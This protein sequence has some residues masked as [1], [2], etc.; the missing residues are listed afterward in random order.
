MTSGSPADDVVPADA[1][2]DYAG[3]DQTARDLGKAEVDDL[4][5]AE[6]ARE[7]G[8]RLDIDCVRET[9][10]RAGR[11]RTTLRDFQTDQFRSQLRQAADVP[12][13][14][15]LG[16][17]DLASE[18][19][20]FDVVGQ[21]PMLDKAT[22]R[23]RLVDYCSDDIDPDACTAAVT[24]GTT[25]V[26]V[27]LVH[28]RA[29]HVQSAAAALNHVASWGL[30]ARRRIL[31]PCQARYVGWFAYSS[32]AR[33][34]SLVA[35]FGV[36]RRDQAQER[37][38]VRLSRNFR[39]DVL[40]AHPTHVL[41]YMTLLER[42]PGRGPRL[43]AVICFGETLTSALASRIVDFFGCPVRDMIGLREFSTIAAQCWAGSY[44]V[45]SER[46]WIEVVDPVTGAPLPE[47]EAGEMVVTAFD[48]RVMPLLR[49][50]TG[51]F[52]RLV[53]RRCECGKP[54]KV[55]EDFSGRDPGRIQLRD[56]RT[57]DALVT[58]GALR[59]LP[60]ER[61][62]VVNPAPGELQVLVTPDGYCGT[63]SHDQ[64]AKSVVQAVQK[65]V[66]GAVTVR[67]M[68]VAPQ[69]FVRSGPEGKMVDFISRVDT[70]E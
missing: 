22:L 38:M 64:L 67:V 60:I 59:A 27:T 46:C 18:P 8:L 10:E 15:G 26:P 40:F 70:G 16:L 17:A 21:L 44:H 61:F 11:A 50:R 1:S 20:P 12:A 19:D 62:Q 45:E 58:R 31:R 24:S 6:A 49:Y 52:V 39:P 9:F 43:R 55:F 51:D 13:Y 68:M 25:G 5:L 14:R 4:L 66:D 47:E 53:D 54:H 41:D 32:P 30:P 2:I 7:R 48:N 63:E 28:D 33:A 3:P 37:E 69:D 57:I 65:F 36:D 29:H 42:F 34:D 35:R 56:G 23:K